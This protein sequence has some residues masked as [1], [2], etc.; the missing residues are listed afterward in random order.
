MLTIEGY[1]VWLIYIVFV[2]TTYFICCNWHIQSIK[3]TYFVF[4]VFFYLFTFIIILC[5]SYTVFGRRDKEEREVEE[6]EIGEKSY[7]SLVWLWWERGE[8]EL[9]PV[10]SIIFRV[11][12]W[13]EEIGE[14]VPIFANFQFY[15][16]IA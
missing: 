8:R 1:I 2:I 3:H 13:W 15:P 5:I 14:R 16:S 9:K 7:S 4:F 6:R 10:G 12:S 11:F